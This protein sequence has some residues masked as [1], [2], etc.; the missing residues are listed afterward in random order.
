MVMD[1]TTIA[2]LLR[3]MHLYTLGIQWLAFVIATRVRM[4][5]TDKS[6]EYGATVLQGHS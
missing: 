4:G 6:Y 2:M 1:V 5:K 3:I